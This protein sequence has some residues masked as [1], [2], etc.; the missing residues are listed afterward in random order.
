MENIDQ[1]N[2]EQ[3]VEIV[4]QTIKSGKPEK[5]IKG[6]SPLFG[7]KDIDIIKSLP[8]DDLHCC[9]I[10][11]NEL[12]LDLW[13]ESSSHGKPFYLGLR[14]QEIDSRLLNFT[15]PRN[16]S[17]SPR[18][19]SER[20]F[21]KGNEHRSWL[22]YYGIPCLVQILPKKYLD[23]FALFSESI[24][25]LSKSKIT[26]SEVEIAK[27]NLTNFVKDFSTLYSPLKMMYN[28]H[29][30]SHITDSVINTGPLWATSTFHFESNNGK[31]VNFV[32]GTKDPMKQI[33]SKFFLSYNLLHDGKISATVLFYLDYMNSKNRTKNSVSVGLNVV[34]LG[35]GNTFNLN[36]EE[37]GIIDDNGTKNWKY[38]VKIIVN[39]EIFS[40]PYPVS[41]KTDDSFIK[42][43][44]GSFGRIKKIIYD[45]ENVMIVVQNLNIEINKINCNHFNS[46]TFAS[47]LQVICPNDIICKC[48]YV[49]SKS[50]NFII[51]FP[52][53]YQKY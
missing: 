46:F 39:N 7:I 12:L 29:L 3:T 15:P 32:H 11:V 53:K 33:F 47:T 28:V 13:L 43:R 4:K 34:L 52:N 30:L 45:S 2:H 24:F 35:K 21:W 49:M 16:F 20:K 23:H 36:E 19:L 26:F 14:K 25:L 37:K 22:F 42:L 38:F 44:N 40:V 10:G 17:R 41:A 18:S 48:I 51:E 9:Y 8:I 31:L 6:I 1:R 50:Y 5:G 27:K